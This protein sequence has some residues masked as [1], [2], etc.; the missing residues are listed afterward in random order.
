MLKIQ[1]RQQKIILKIQQVKIKMLK[2][3]DIFQ[4]LILLIIQII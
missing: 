1:L 4:I 2:K 3:R